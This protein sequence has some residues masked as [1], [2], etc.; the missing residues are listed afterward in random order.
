MHKHVRLQKERIYI[1][2]FPP[3]ITAEVCGGQKDLYKSQGLKGHQEE[4]EGCS[5]GL[6]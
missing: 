6:E 4:T 2:G 1:L 5:K 3:Q